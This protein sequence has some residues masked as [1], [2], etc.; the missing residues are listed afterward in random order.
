MNFK[1]VENTGEAL[2][3]DEDSREEFCHDASYVFVHFGCKSTKPYKIT[4]QI[5]RRYCDDN[6]KTSNLNGCTEETCSIT[7]EQLEWIL[8]KVKSMEWYKKTNV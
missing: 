3:Y 1:V 7:Q 4:A 6:N 8:E 2:W 5:F